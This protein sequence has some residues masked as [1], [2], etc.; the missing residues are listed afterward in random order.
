M[1]S[2]SRLVGVGDVPEAEA[3]EAD[4]DTLA[5]EEGSPTIGAEADAEVSVALGS[6]GVLDGRKD[7]SKR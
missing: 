2:D 7:C 6:I 1:G 4:G 5:D 3:F